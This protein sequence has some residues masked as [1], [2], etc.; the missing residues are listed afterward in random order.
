MRNGWACAWCGRSRFRMPSKCTATGTMVLKK[1]SAI[2]LCVPLIAANTDWLRF[3][4]VE[5]HMGT[6]FRITLYAPDVEV[7]RSGFDAAFARVIELDDI[8]S[9]YKPE[10]E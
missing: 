6:L 10:S 8:L 4:R 2:L 5:P 3:E 1:S 9:D 7:A